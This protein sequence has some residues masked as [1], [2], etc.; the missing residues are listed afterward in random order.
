MK[1]NDFLCTLRYVWRK[2]IKSDKALS[3]QGAV[4]GREQGRWPTGCAS[5]D[6]LE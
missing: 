2:S 3:C 4:D 5:D 1:A 6:V